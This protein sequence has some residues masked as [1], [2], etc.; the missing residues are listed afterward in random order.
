MLEEE[1]YALSV[2]GSAAGFGQLLNTQLVQGSRKYAMMSVAYSRRDINRHNPVTQLLLL[3]MGDCVG[4]YQVA[5]LAVVDL[6]D[7]IAAENTVGDNGNSGGCAVL[8]DDV[9]GFAEGST[10]VC[11]VVDDDSCAALDITNQD[12]AADFVRTSTFLV[13]EREFDVEAVCDCSCSGIA[14]SAKWPQEAC[15]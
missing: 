3:L 5:Q 1:R 2:V 12:H 10:G 14:A 13:N 9:S 15:L 6:V 7:R 8:N 4:D 11:H